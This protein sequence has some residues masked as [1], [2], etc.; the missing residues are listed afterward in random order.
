[1]G[2]RG[3]CPLGYRER[4]SVS[5]KAEAGIS[6][7]DSYRARLLSSAFAKGIPALKSSSSVSKSHTS[8]WVMLAWR[9]GPQDWCAEEFEGPRKGDLIENLGFG[10]VVVR[11]RRTRSPCPNAQLG[12]EVMR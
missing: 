9:S 12:G 8:D 6:A 10:V 2:S 11:A 1:M 5:A 3:F 7:T 4:R